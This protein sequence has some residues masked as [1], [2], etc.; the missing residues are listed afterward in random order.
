MFNLS[1]PPGNIHPIRLRTVGW[2]YGVKLTQTNW[3]AQPPPRL[4]CGTS[5][6]AAFSNVVLWLPASLTKGAGPDR[7]CLAIPC[8]QQE[9]N[10]DLQ[11]R[12]SSPVPI[13]SRSHTAQIKRKSPKSAYNNSCGPHSTR[14]REHATGM[15][16]VL[17]APAVQ[18]P[19]NRTGQLLFTARE[20]PNR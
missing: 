4:C 6:L 10:G 20:L 13:H 14:G 11:S 8:G 18:L 12:N 16:Q 3:K 2:L 17:N 5:I 19:E 15:R 9:D 7:D 1:L